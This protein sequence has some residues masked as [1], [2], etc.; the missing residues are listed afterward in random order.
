MIGVLQFVHSHFVHFR[1][2]SE[3]L[4]TCDDMR[5]PAGRMQRSPGLG[6][7]RS[8]RRRTFSDHYSRTRVCDLLFQLEDLLRKRVNLGVLF[9]YLFRQRFKLSVIICFAR[10]RRGR[11]SRSNANQPEKECRA[12]NQS[13]LHRRKTLPS[14]DLSGKRHQNGSAIH[15]WCNSSTDFGFNLF[16]GSTVKLF[17]NGKRAACLSNICS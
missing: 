2:G 8:C 14:A 16:Y 7:R 4:A 11:L 15:N 10:L 6:G 5:V 12:K 13:E 3:C 1:D 9:V 17:N